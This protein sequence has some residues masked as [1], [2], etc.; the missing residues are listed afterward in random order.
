LINIDSFVH[1]DPTIKLGAS[2][3]CL[4]AKKGLACEQALKSRMG[5]RKREERRQRREEGRKG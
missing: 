3:T 5:W 4:K 1:S 2:K